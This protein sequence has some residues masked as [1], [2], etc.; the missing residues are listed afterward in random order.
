M[1]FQSFGAPIALFEMGN[2]LDKAEIP[3]KVEI[4]EIVEK[5]ARSWSEIRRMREVMAYLAGR[6]CSAS[7]EIMP[8]WIYGEHNTLR[9]FAVSHNIKYR[10]DRSWSS[11]AP[12]SER[13]IDLLSHAPDQISACSG[14]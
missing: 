10:R 7:Y 9:R 2:F 4:K 11:S 13:T 12:S 5:S 14:D 3:V 6:N 8:N 1:R